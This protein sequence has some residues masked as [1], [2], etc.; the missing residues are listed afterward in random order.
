MTFSPLSAMRKKYDAFWDRF[1]SSGR[2][3]IEASG[4]DKSGNAISGN[5]KLLHGRNIIVNSVCPQLCGM[6]FV[7]LSLLLTLVGGTHQK[8]SGNE[9]TYKSTG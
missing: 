2:G 7:K 3:P 4:D 9:R 1:R 5:S 6:F 8:Q